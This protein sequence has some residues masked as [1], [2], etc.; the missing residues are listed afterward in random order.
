METASDP[1][2][3]LYFQTNPYIFSEKVTKFGWIIFL[4]RWV[5]G[6]N[7]KGGAEHP[8]TGRIG[9]N[10]YKLQLWKYQVYPRGSPPRAT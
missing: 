4:P 10:R 2:S 8:P 1:Y 3:S 6:K 5:I 9:L 7:L